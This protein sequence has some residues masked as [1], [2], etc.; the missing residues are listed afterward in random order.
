MS[1]SSAASSRGAGHS[2]LVAVAL[3]V[4]LGLA[5]SHSDGAPKQGLTSLLVSAFLAA[6]N[7][8]PQEANHPLLMIPM[9]CCLGLFLGL[10]VG[11]VYGLLGG[12]S[13]GGGG[14]SV[15]AAKAG[16]DALPIFLFVTLVMLFHIAELAFV[17]F[18]HPDDV[19]FRSLM[20]SPVPYGGYSLAMIAAFAEY[21][22]ESMLFSSLSSSSASSSAASPTT[23]GPW[24]GGAVTLV[25][26]VFGL[27][28]WGLRAAALFT[29]Q[30]NFT[31]LVAYFKVADHTLVTSGVYGLC[32]H[33]GYV[34]WFLWSVSTQVV[35]RNPICWVM[36][37]YVSWRFFAGRIPPEEQTLLHF[38]GDAY[39][40]YARRVPCGIP[41]ISLLDS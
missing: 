25:G 16:G 8:I 37:F 5:L 30:S 35:L 11:A 7:F 20:L 6:S 10:S 29:A 27:L 1:S 21:W 4:G 32:R 15:I 23:K 33:P 38:F 22:L 12:V 36:Y 26:F 24:I 9:A 2:S 13:F 18:Y 19:S 40:S 17:V 3:G 14:I 41:G 34:G 39:M 31:H 28:G